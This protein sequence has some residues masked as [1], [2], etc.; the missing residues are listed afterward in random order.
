[1]NKDTVVGIVGAAILVT[2]MVGIFYYERGVA[3][4][5]GIGGP[6]GPGTNANTTGPTVTGTVAL[7]S[8]DSKLANITAASAGNVTFRL[9]WTATNGADTLQ[10]TV[11]PPTGS[12]IMEGS[13]SEPSDSGEITVTVAVPA[14]ATPTGE[15][16]VDVSFTQ[17]TPDPLP[18]GVP[19][20]TNPPGST[21][22]SVDYRVAVT[23]R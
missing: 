19:P 3:A 2:A 10:I 17:A 13:V 21:D 18:G 1:M 12:G 9:T 4:D 11:A 8:T 20:P 6:G 7:G 14:G 22:T 15:W 16:K 23:L 5:G